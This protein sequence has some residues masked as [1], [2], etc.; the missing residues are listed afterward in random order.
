MRNEIRDFDDEPGFHCSCH[1]RFLL[2]L[3][4]GF[5]PTFQNELDPTKIRVGFSEE[6]ELSFGSCFLYVFF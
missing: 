1:V 5:G 3:L 2:L 6:G 4:K